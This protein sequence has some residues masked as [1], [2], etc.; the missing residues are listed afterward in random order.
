MILTKTCH[1][2]YTLACRNELPG[3][4]RASGFSLIRRNVL[5]GLAI[6]FN[7][8]GYEHKQMVLALN[9]VFNQK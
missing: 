1:D 4:C 6:M 2:D 5:M 7:R 9:N 8:C 3:A